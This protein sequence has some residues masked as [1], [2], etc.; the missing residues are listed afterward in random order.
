[1]TL[2]NLLCKLSQP[3]Q[4]MALQ[5]SWRMPYIRGESSGRSKIAMN[6]HSTMATPRCKHSQPQFSQ[7][8]CKVRASTLLDS[9]TQ[10]PHKPWVWALARH[11]HLHL[12][13]LPG[14]QHQV[15]KGANKPTWNWELV[16]LSGSAN[17]SSSV[18][19]LFRQ[20]GEIQSPW[21]ELFSKA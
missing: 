2:T 9:I 16:N 5:L 11:F 10:G 8:V 6:K 19:I 3:W 14:L 4:I 21:K 7:P 15:W 13:R 12:L 17:I 18:N 1:M 20:G